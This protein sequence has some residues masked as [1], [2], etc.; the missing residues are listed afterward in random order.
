M[1]RNPI[2]KR[3]QICLGI[4]SVITCV[5][6]Y[7]WMS[8]RQHQINPKDTT[9]PNASQFL[10]GIKKIIAKDVSGNMWITDDS[11][12]TGSRLFMGM[13]AGVLLS[14]IFGIAMGTW[15][16]AEAFLKWPISMLANIPPTAMLAVYFVLFGT[17]LKM[18]TAM[19]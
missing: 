12:A 5:L 18:F 10:E 9:I 6:L 3:T 15:K 17:E 11:W 13:G 7:S 4:A 2:T 1:I 19:K 16:P 8:Y 14:I